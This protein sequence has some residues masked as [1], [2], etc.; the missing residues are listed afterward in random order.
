MHL[1]DSGLSQ[2]KPGGRGWV[3]TVPWVPKHKDL[4]KLLPNEKAWLSLNS[5]K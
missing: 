3:H 4:R 1:T 5:H 2:A